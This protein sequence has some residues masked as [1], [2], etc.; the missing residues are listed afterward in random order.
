MLLNFDVEAKSCQKG[1]EAKVEAETEAY[2]FGL[3]A[4]TSL[5]KTYNMI[6]QLSFKAEHVCGQ[7]KFLLHY[8]LKFLLART[9]S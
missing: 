3:G 9:F 4:S 8:F 1:P 7:L 2:Q 6:F 5:L